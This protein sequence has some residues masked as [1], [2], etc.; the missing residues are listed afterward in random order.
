MKNK[1]KISNQLNKLSYYVL[2]LVL[3]LF[4]LINIISGQK[5]SNL[6]LGLIN[7]N[8]NTTIN[9]LKKI[10]K[11]PE[12]EREL[13]KFTMLFG[14]DI[15]DL[16]FQEEKELEHKINQMEKILEKNSKARDVL[17]ALS[18]LY[19][20]KGD[21]KKAQEYLKKVYEIDPFFKK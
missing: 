2:G 5:I 19:Q 18:Q 15:K 10:K 14:K 7:Q 12:F 21:Y 11:L 1:L 4:V 3:F 20:K 16:V 6:Y 9:Y 17:Y 13:K 8:K